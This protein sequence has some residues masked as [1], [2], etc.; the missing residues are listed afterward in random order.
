MIQVI[1]MSMNPIS[2]PGMIPPAN[3][4]PTEMLP[5]LARMIIAMLGGMIPPIVPL[6]AVIAAAKLAL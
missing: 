2:S 5:A 4:A 6:T 3:R 1:A